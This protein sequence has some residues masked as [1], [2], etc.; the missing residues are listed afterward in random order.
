MRLKDIN[1]GFALTGSFCTLDTVTEQMRK[2]KEEEGANLIP[3][4][5]Y[6]VAELDTKFGEAAKW[7]E[8]LADMG[9]P[10]PIDTIPDAEPIGTKGLFDILVIAPCSG[11]TIAKLA[12]G[13]TDTPALMAAKAHL[14][15]ARPVVLA[16]S[17]N[18]GLGFNGKNIGL[19]LNAKNIY[20]VPF[21]Q[22]NPQGKP[23]SL[24]AKMELIAD[25]VAAALD[26]KQI[27]PILVQH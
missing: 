20:M 1:V 7:R 27:Q 8:K 6:H 23:N 16:V 24:L 19:L 11:N 5:S 10:Q 9:C 26:G 2:L 21:G 15:N 25:T 18:D 22:D 17:T 4:F 12:S 3:V 14:R 13:I